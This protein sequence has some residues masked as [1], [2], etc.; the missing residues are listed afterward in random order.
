MSFAGIIVKVDVSEFVNYLN[1]LDSSAYR[2]S[3][4]VLGSCASITAREIKQ[5]APVSKYPRI[6]DRYYSRGRLKRSIS[7]RRL[8][9][10]WVIEGVMYGLFFQTGTKGWSKS[11]SKPYVFEVRRYRRKDRTWKTSNIVVTRKVIRA[12]RVPRNRFISKGVRKAIPKMERAISELTEK[13]L[14][15]G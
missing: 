4:E 15:G 8:T 14:R 9:N 2:A 5:L 13:Y 1:Y 3:I 6:F 10:I 12:G 11:R 7:A